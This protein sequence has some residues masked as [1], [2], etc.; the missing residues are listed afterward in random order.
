M[1]ARKSAPFR[2]VSRGVRK[3][4]TV[5]LS[6]RN[7]MLYLNDWF[8]PLVHSKTGY[9]ILM[10]LVSYLVVIVVFA[11]I[12]HVIDE[13]TNCQ[14]GLHGGYRAAFFFSLETHAT[15]GYGVPGADTS[16][17]SCNPM[18]LV[19][20]LQTFIALLSDAVLIGVFF[21]RMSRGTKRAAQ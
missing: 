1:M 7:K 20:Y 14:I 19:L 11:A 5:G 16:F 18:I 3:P 10:F 2:L 6:W 13:N 17:H 12:Y 4:N 21:A 9:L 8:Y 15:I